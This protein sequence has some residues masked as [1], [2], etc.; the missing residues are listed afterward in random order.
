MSF[1]YVLW[2]KAIEKIKST[3]YLTKI[4]KKI[5]CICQ[6]IDS[7]DT[8]NIVYFFQI[9]CVKCLLNINIHTPWRIDLKSSLIILFITFFLS[10]LGSS[11]GRLKQLKSLNLA[12]NKLS[13]FPTRWVYWYPNFF[14]D[15]LTNLFFN[16]HYTLKILN[17]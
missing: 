5:R 6:G 13:V 4:K 8:V 3:V 9:V 15:Q 17:F 14:I 12:H 7:G 1:Q 11:L 16:I 2:R 10:M